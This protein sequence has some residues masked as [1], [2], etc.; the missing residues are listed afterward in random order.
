MGTKVKLGKWK[1]IW[2]CMECL[3]LGTINYPLYTKRK[4]VAN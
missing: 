3:K 4:R 1:N 2:K